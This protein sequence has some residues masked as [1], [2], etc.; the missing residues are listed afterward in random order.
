MLLLTSLNYFAVIVAAIVYFA[1]G[2]VWYTPLFGKLWAKESGV[3]MGNSPNV[4]FPMIGQFISTFLFTVGIAFLVQMMNKTGFLAGIVTGLAVIIFFIFPIN[5][6][7]LFFKAKP[8]LF[9]IEAGY[10]SIGALVIGIILA[11]WR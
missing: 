2:A 5:S 7:T 9:F 3:T 10:Q 6:G 4:L 1:I 8:I 11:L